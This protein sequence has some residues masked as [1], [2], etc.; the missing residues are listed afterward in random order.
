MSS[1]LLAVPNEIL[2]HIAF[3]LASLSLHAHPDLLLP[4]RHASTSL[5]F[6]L[7]PDANPSLYARIYRLK[8]DSS[9]IRRRAFD[10]QAEDYA[11][12]LA[13]SCKTLAAIQNRNFFAD[14]PESVLFAAYLMMLDNDGKNRAQLEW[15]GIDAYV[16]AYVRTRTYDPIQRMTNHGWPV[17]NAANACA[18]W[19]MWMLTTPE[20]LQAESLQEREQIALSVLPFA[21]VPFRY[22]SAHAPPMHYYLPL[23]N[24]VN[25]GD[26]EFFSIQTAHGPFPIYRSPE[27]AWSQLYFA[28]RPLIMPPLAAEAA[29]LIYISRRDM[30]PFAIP[31]ALPRNR[32]AAVA[33]G[34][35]EVMPTQEDIVE[36]N[37]HKSAK[38]VK[39]IIWDW[40]QGKAVF[41]GENNEVE[42]VDASRAWDCDW[43]RLRLCWDSWRRQP[44]WRPGRVY[45]PGTMSGLWEG[46][47]L[48]PS[49]G[50]MLTFLNNAS[51]PSPLYTEDT[52][53]I[54]SR[55]IYMRIKEHHC[56]MNQAPMP[57]PGY[58]T[59]VNNLANHQPAQQIP[60]EGTQNAWFPG[61]TG[62]L[63]HEYSFDRT[64]AN[65]TLYA[66]TGE[67]AQYQTFVPENNNARWTGHEHD[68]D[69]CDA[70]RARA[71]VVSTAVREEKQRMELE[72]ERRR[73]IEQAFTSVGLGHGF[74]VPL[75]LENDEMDVDEDDGEEDE[76]DGDL[77]IMEMSEDAE[78]LFTP[79]GQPLRRVRKS[80]DWVRN[81]VECDGIKDI[82]FTGATDDSHGQAWHHYTFYGRVRPWDGL[83]GIL[84]VPR[85]ALQGTTI[86][87]G[88]VSGSKNFSGNWRFALTDP[89]M[90]AW[91]CAVVMSKREGD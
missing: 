57:V 67:T 8:F 23:P 62:S 13:L 12:H 39:R 9:A 19:L 44:R 85:L 21:S 76:E 71:E 79:D 22:A 91:E 29:K 59:Y 82:I 86:L 61:P 36:L 70:C 48:I 37:A 49:E 40:D 20:K 73:E 45:M 78:E 66:V 55:P 10:P 24:A 33:A 90:P 50:Q 32:V 1:L 88:Y 64:G 63:R 4:L 75:G 7:S 3:H 28:S 65:V 18:L 89:G 35:T 43:W 41:P 77:D 54:T 53:N 34:L 42:Y 14:A 81:V 38:L 84:R 68:N 56:L 11:E 15:A 52:L 26:A 69:A 58:H 6:R 83:I 25:N 60:E 16:D 74:G 46:K 72:E 30:T 51:Y 5:Y 2:T 87:Y 80:H 17:D 27:R 31:P 47:L